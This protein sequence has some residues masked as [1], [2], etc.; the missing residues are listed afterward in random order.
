MLTGLHWV[1]EKGIHVHTIIDV[2]ASDGK[3][4]LE[5]MECFPEQQYLLLE[6]NP[7]HAESLISFAR[8]HTNCIPD[9]RAIGASNG[10]VQFKIESLWGGAMDPNGD[11]LN[12][13]T[14]PMVTLDTCVDEHHL[15]GPFLVKLDT[16]GFEKGIFDGAD[17]VL[18]S[19]SVLVVEC[20]NFKITDEALQFWDF[21]AYLRGKGFRPAK[22]VD[23][24]DRKLDG[25]LWQ[26]DIFFLKDSWQGFENL[27]YQ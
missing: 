12:S 24:H 26:M 19:A 27:N 16:H 25:T 21:C 14:V 17:E 10:C 23:V 4:S 7:V 5:S 22:I 11:S 20:Y 9:K 6:P 1:R 13:I 18:K 8:A 3:W 2:G 15:K